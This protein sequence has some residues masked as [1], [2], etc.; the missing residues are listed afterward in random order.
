MDPKRVF[1]GAAF[2]VFALSLSGG[3]FSSSVTYDFSGVVTSYD[4]YGSGLTV[5]LGS[6]VSGTYIFNL[7]GG[8]S[9]GTVGSASW[10]VGTQ[11]GPSYG[12]PLP[13]SSVFVTSLQAG[14]FS[15]TSTT[16]SPSNS[17]D[18]W[19]GY[20]SSVTGAGTS[21]NASEQWQA[22]PDI[23]GGSSLSI[24]NPHGAY[25][26]TGLPIF[27]G[28]TSA[29]GDVSEFIASQP[30]QLDYTITSMKL[31][32]AA[33]EIDRSSAVSVLTLV[34]GG[35]AVTCARPRCRAV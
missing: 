23:L 13:T 7:A 6:I 35:L 32:T 25:S 34:L 31:A 17:G 21:F 1:A 29:T 10:S 4:N 19:A 30:T 2:F 20:Q 9:S 26:S 15:Y 28:S 22:A 14:N 18:P 12:T 24:T 33:P 5:P 16:P 8:N 3:A 27:A 11:G